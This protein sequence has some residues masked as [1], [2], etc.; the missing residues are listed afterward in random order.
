M[1][2]GLQSRVCRVKVVYVHQ[3]A[4]LLVSSHKRRGVTVVVE[5]VECVPVPRIITLL[6]VLGGGSVSWVRRMW[7]N[8]G[9]T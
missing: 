1:A 9:A 8:C 5:T 6:S 2:T 4:W 3:R 7:C